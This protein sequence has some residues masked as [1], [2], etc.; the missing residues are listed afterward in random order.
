MRIAKD[1]T[2]EISLIN[3]DVSSFRLILGLAISRLQNCPMQQMIGTPLNVQDGIKG[4]DLI[5]VKDMLTKLADE[6][7]LGEPNLEPAAVKQ[8]IE[9]LER[10][11][12]QPASP[13][14]PKIG[15]YLAGQGGIY[16]GNIQGDDG[17][18]Y[19]LIIA[20]PQDVGAAR[21]APDGERDL[22]EWD[23]LTNTSRLRNECPAAKLASDYEADG[24]IDFYLPSRREMMV[25]LANVPH[26]FSKEGWYWTST[27]RSESYAWAVDF[28]DGLVDFFYRSSEFRVRPFRRF[29]L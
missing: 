16:A 15:E 11:P 27:P 13:S 1:H 10:Q 21:W 14:R 7:D 23:G 5:D 4:R 20:K 2:V 29:P 19:G 25:A 24:N 9:Q 6:F 18:L 17:V 26:L 8:L 3:R 22:S 28:E 12:H